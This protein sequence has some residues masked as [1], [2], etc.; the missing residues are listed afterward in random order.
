M[1][2]GGA[3]LLALLLGALLLACSFSPTTVVGRAGHAGITYSFNPAK[4]DAAT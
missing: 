1:R 4:S 3:V 2:R